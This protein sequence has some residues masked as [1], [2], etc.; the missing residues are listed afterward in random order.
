MNRRR[1][2]LAAST[3]TAALLSGCAAGLGSK[4]LA[5]TFHIDSSDPYAELKKFKSAVN[6]L[7]ARLTVSFQH[8]FSI[9]ELYKEGP[10]GDEIMQQSLKDI[11]RLHAELGKYLSQAA[12]VR[13]T[14]KPEHAELLK[15]FDAYVQALG[16]VAGIDY[17]DISQESID[18]LVRAG[19]A[20][21]PLIP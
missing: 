15:A 4:D 5:G 10:R 8:L 21:E 7:T 18:A 6:M 1:L 9:G 19:S 13:K 11:R 3:L 2:L 14:I 17:G 16:G 20:M 12:E